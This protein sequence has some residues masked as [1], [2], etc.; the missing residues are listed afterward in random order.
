MGVKGIYCP[1]LGIKK[2]D[3]NKLKWWIL[4]GVLIGV[5]FGGLLVKFKHKIAEKLGNLL[6]K[7]IKNQTEKRNIQELK[8]T[9]KK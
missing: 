1:V 3:E 5:I 8:T 6:K 4:F 2:E 7:K 9:S